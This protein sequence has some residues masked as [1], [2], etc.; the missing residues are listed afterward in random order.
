M[1]ESRIK[2]TVQDIVNS[3]DGAALWGDKKACCN[4]VVRLDVNNKDHHALLWCSLK[5]IDSLKGVHAGTILVDKG[6]SK[7][8]T[9]THCNYILVDNPRAA[10]KHVISKF[11]IPLPLPAAIS[12]YAVV[13]P[14]VNIDD[15]VTIGHFT[16]I[17]KNCIIG[18]NVRIGNNTVILENTII[19]DNVAIGSNCTIG[20]VGFGYEKSATGEYDLIHHIGNVILGRNVEIGNNTCIDRAVLGST[21][22]GENVKIDNLVHIAHGVEVKKNSLIIA[23]AMIAGSC[24]IGENV[25]IAPSSAIKNKLKINDNSL[26]GIGAVVLNDIESNDTVVG[27]PGRSIKRK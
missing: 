13:D 16:T 3:L 6:I 18:K 21:L 1:S 14:S 8:M 26:V 25:W 20:G 12:K 4:K 17:E 2:L 10:F 11:F 19:E 27:N 9:N 22:I 24:S 7:Q 5:N 15:S 23:N